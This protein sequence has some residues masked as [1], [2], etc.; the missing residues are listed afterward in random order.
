M[1]DKIDKNEIFKWTDE[2]DYMQSL[3][4]F[5]NSHPNPPSSQDIQVY[6]ILT[7]NTE[8]YIPSKLD[9]K[10]YKYILLFI[11]SHIRKNSKGFTRK[12]TIVI[13]SNVK[14]KRMVDFLNDND[15]MYL[16]KD[17]ENLNL[18][19]ESKNEHDNKLTSIE[20][21]EITTDNAYTF[22]LFIHR[23]YDILIYFN[24]ISIDNIDLSE[25]QSESTQ[26]NKKHSTEKSSFRQNQP[27][28]SINIQNE[29]NP[30]LGNRL[31]IP[32][33]SNIN[34]S[35]SVG[36]VNPDFVDTVKA[37]LEYILSEAGIIANN[38]PPYNF[39][40]L[41]QFKLVINNNNNCIYEPYNLNICQVLNH[42]QNEYMGKGEDKHKI[43]IRI[44]NNN[45]AAPSYIGNHSGIVD[46]LFK[47]ILEPN[48]GN[49][50]KLSRILNRRGLTAVQRKKLKNRGVR[51]RLK[52]RWGRNPF[53]KYG[54]KRKTSYKT[55][56]TKKKNNYK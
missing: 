43:F 39:L 41:R 51:Y 47:K 19:I 49:W 31:S 1:E 3:Q 20:T 25:G 18:K 28:N 23:I 9:E 42:I 56:Q 29:L 27:V 4:I 13:S 24:I 45:N 6:D 54:G 35:F 7:N 21:I 34:D 50:N 33:V 46:D 53:T 14:V 30:T 52:Y 16:G 12:L 44:Y 40:D 37:V 5:L 26:P 15:Y 32:P 38:G 48:T 55:R 2:G 8:L 17:K 10:I 22:P 36:T 11:Y